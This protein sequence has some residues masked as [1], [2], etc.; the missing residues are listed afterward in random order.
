MAGRKKSVLNSELTGTEVVEEPNVID[1][2][3]KLIEENHQM[4]TDEILDAQQ[5]NAK[6]ANTEEA[7]S[8]SNN[9]TSTKSEDL[10]IAKLLDQINVIVA[11]A[12][13]EYVKSTN[14][15]NA[16][17]A[18]EA[19]APSVESD[20]KVL[21][22]NVNGFQK[23]FNPKTDKQILHGKEYLSDEQIVANI[24]KNYES[25]D[26]DIIAALFAIEKNYVFNIRYQEYAMCEKDVM[27]Y[28][29]Y[30]TNVLLE[31][32]IKV[33]KREEKLVERKAKRIIRSEERS[34]RRQEEQAAYRETVKDLLD[35]LEKH[36][37]E[38]NSNATEA[39]FDMGGNPA[40]A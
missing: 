36:V 13:K 40:T 32:M 28:A 12:I 16:T 9:A 24:H 25:V 11:N 33:H 18:Q 27:W 14:S 26:E 39:G 22:N 23:F 2:E 15:N 7:A 17:A 8:N 6:S 21:E 1:V 10:D 3:A 5:K 38:V 19:T 34:K 29:V 37:G 31:K 35:R 20:R 30:N 4:T